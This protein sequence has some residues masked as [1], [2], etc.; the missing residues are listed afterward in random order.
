MSGLVIVPLTDCSTTLYGSGGNFQQWAKTPAG[1]Q[2]S[3]PGW[4]APIVGRTNEE[5]LW[6]R[7]FDPLTNQPIVRPMDETQPVIVNVYA[8]E[9]VELDLA[10]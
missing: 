6:S 1:C 5:W 10:G 7:D 4:S 3:G 9:T 8:P 2:P